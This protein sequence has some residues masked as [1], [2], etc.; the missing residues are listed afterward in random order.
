ML[1]TTARLANAVCLGLLSTVSL[2]AVADGQLSASYLTSKPLALEVRYCDCA[3]IGTDD[4][5]PKL[6]PEFLRESD[7]LRV[8]I[9]ATDKRFISSRDF[10]IGYE[11]EPASDRPGSFV[12]EYASAYRGNAGKYDSQAKLVLATGEWIHLSGSRHVS[13]SGDQVFGIAVRLV[14]SP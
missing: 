13:E 3:A 14:E 10:T 5:S 9:S 11:I 6:L 7:R 1:K 12:F 4:V 2:P 8:G